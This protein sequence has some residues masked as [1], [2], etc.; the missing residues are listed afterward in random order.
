MLSSS[1]T[2]P[3]LPIAFHL[4]LRIFA[5][6]LLVLLICLLG[7]R[8]DHRFAPQAPIVVMSLCCFESLPH[9]IPSVVSQIECR[10]PIRSFIHAREVSSPP[11][12]TRMGC[13]EFLSETSPS[14]FA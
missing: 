6:R 8:V 7:R 10:G 14:N 13:H 2:A 5:R 11:S 4:G 1:S 12:I 3:Y 9:Y